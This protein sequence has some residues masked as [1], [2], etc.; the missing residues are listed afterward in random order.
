MNA[1]VE[2][3]A[4]R[5]RSERGRSGRPARWGRPLSDTIARRLR[6][7]DW[8][9]VTALIS[10]GFGLAG[11]IVNAFSLVFVSAIFAAAALWGLFEVE[12]VE[13]A[14]HRYPGGDQ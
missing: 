5:A 6:R 2:S 11:L 10:I 12:R 4:P 9:T 8:V 1:R 14:D 13:L 3:P 7:V